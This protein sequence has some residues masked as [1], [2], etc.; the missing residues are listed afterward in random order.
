VSTDVL[1]QVVPGG[2]RAV[3]GVES[4]KLNQ[5]RGREVMAKISQPRNLRFHRKFFALLGVAIDMADTNM[6]DEQF[7]AYNTAGAGW[8]DF[9][10]GHDGNLVAVP[11]SISFGKMD[12]TTFNR[13]YQDVLTFIVRRWKLDEQQL[14]RMVDFM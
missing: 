3:N 13:L 11:K 10:P 14:S 5:L 12:E 1:V 2:L 7:R 6:N 9:I 4:D 8:C